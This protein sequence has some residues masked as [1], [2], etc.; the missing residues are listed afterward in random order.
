MIAATLTGERELADRLAAIPAAVQDSL[1][2]RILQLTAALQRQVAEHKLAGQVLAIRSGGLRR[3]V[4]QTVEERRDEILGRVG[5][6]GSVPYGAIHEFGG[7]TPAHAIQTKR[8]R[9]LAF[10]RDGKTVFAARVSH[11]GSAL[12]ER[13]FLRSALADLGPEIRAALAAAVSEGLRSARP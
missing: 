12:P 4:A 7:R 3:S 1:L 11:P 10:A 13:S 5:L 8:A 6:D 2:R 9:V